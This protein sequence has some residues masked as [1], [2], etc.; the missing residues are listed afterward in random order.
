MTPSPRQGALRR[1]TDRLLELPLVYQAWQ[2]PFASAKLKPF[3]E[4]AGLARMRRVLDVGCGP[5]TNARV[6]AGAEYVGIDINPEYIRVAASRYPGRFVVGD[7]T[8]E[9]IF[10]DEQFDCV[11]ANSLMHHLDDVSAGNLLARM[12]R[13]TVPGG[14]VHVLDLVLPPQLSTGRVLAQLDRGRFA[15]P[16]EHWHRLFTEH[17]REE[18][19]EPYAFGLPFLPLWNMVYFVGMPK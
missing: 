13:L 10:P 2:A 16:V 17:M 12:A 6:F 4:H 5:G 15:R 3:V 9:S 18:R 14:R 11:F 8:D 7:V 19:F 1:A